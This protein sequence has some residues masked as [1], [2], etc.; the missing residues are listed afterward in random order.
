MSSVAAKGRVLRMPYSINQTSFRPHTYPVLP[1][2]LATLPGPVF[3]QLSTQLTDYST[4]VL[5]TS[6]YR[7]QILYKLSAYLQIISR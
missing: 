7:Q 2:C 4:E 6:P 1:K 5:T 3:A